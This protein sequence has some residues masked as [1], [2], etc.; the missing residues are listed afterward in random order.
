MELVVDP[1]GREVELIRS[2]YYRMDLPNE[3]CR[4]VPWVVNAE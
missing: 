3:F 2:R 1:V 4:M